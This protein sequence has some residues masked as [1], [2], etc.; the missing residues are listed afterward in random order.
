MS[1][2]FRNVTVCFCCGIKLILDG[3]FWLTSSLTLKIFGVTKVKKE[4]GEHVSP[5]FQTYDQ[6]TNTDHLKYAVVVAMHKGKWVFVRHK[7]RDTF[8]IP[9]GKREPGETIFEAA[10]RELVEETGA[11]NFEIYPLDLFSHTS[12]PDKYSGLL[13]YADIKSMGPKP[14]SEIQELA[15]FDETPKAVTHPT[16]HPQLFERAVKRT[17]IIRKVQNYDHVIWDWNGTIVD[18]VA[19][20]VKSVGILLEENNLDPISVSHYKKVFGFPIVD[21]YKKI[22]FDMDSL[23]MDA[24][25]HRFH[26]EYERHR[27]SHSQLFD[28][29]KWTLE[30]LGRHKSQSVLSA[31]AQWHLN[32]WARD[33]EIAHHFDSIFGLDNHLAV[34][35]LDRGK[36]LIEKSPFAKNQTI[37][38]GDT[39]H[40][41]DVAKNLGIDILLIAQGHQSFD[42]LSKMHHNVLETRSVQ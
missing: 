15:Y 20:A 23:C 41:C 1:N 2:G 22:G 21:Y 8:E 18:D 40:D 32:N 26:E 37:L 27:D 30:T 33:F 3:A 29:T 42:R 9:G 31:A 11:V 10:S 25:S 35:K 24:L 19:L 28:D 34:S 12:S 17:R 4:T 6:E 39:D 14:H 13:C 5:S 36:E 7:N 16:M 38:I